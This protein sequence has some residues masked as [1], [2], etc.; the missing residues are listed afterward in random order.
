ML[1]VFPFQ[2]LIY[3]KFAFIKEAYIIHK[4]YAYIIMPPFKEEG[5][6]YFANVCPS[7]DHM[8]SADYLKNYLLQ[9]ITSYF[10]Y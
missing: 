10:I 1:L 4:I 8:V 3:Y 2:G 7:V 9:Y 5:V 6:Y